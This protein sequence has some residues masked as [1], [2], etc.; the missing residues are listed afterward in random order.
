MRS[1]VR[2]FEPGY[3]EIYLLTVYTYKFYQ[4]LQISVFCRKRNGSEI[5][6]KLI[7]LVGLFQA[8]FKS[9]N[10]EFIWIHT[11]KM[12]VTFIL[13]FEYKIFSQ[14]LTK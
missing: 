7:L 11:R 10:K 4:V 14:G 12:L 8:V 6:F 3:F 1:I 2:Y 9:L 13:V 5:M